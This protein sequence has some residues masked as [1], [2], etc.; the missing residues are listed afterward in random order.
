MLVDQAFSLNNVPSSYWMHI[1]AMKLPI[2][3]GW[4]QHNC[5]SSTFLDQQRI[6]GLSHRKYIRW[7]ENPCARDDFSMQASQFWICSLNCCWWVL[8]TILL[9]VIRSQLRNIRFWDSFR[10]ISASFTAISRT[11]QK[12]VAFAPNWVARIKNRACVF[13]SKKQFRRVFGQ[14]AKKYSKPDMVACSSLELV[15]LTDRKSVKMPYRHITGVQQ[16]WAQ[17]HYRST[18]IW[19]KMFLGKLLLLKQRA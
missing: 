13:Q 7:L 9:F 15:L 6:A 5:E 10:V 17:I 16:L 18:S 4:A 11:Q 3:I 1:Q 14:E 12:S 2:S 19:L 8:A